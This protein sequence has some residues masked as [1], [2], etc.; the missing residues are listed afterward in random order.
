MSMEEEMMIS[1]LSWKINLQ[2]ANHD[3]SFSEDRK[4]LT[5]ASGNQLQ[6]FFKK[7]TFACNVFYENFIFGRIGHSICIICILHICIENIVFNTYVYIAGTTMSI[8]Y[9]L[10]QR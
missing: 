2:E 10:P 1:F 4:D 7:S 9:V 5:V 6:P 3:R 8:S